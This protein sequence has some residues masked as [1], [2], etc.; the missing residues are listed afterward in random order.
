MTSKF[1]HKVFSNSDLNFSCI[2]QQ[3]L[4][5]FLWRTVGDKSININ[6]DTHIGPYT[7]HF[8][9]MYPPTSKDITL[10]L[11]NV[12]EKISKENSPLFPDNVRACD[13][14]FDD[15][16]ITQSTQCDGIHTNATWR[17]QEPEPKQL[18]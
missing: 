2:N 11:S 1:R 4:L 18:M 10:C 6:F 14:V 17:A 7:F 9:P 13:V 3:G 8:P 5:R 16:L 15:R 12:L